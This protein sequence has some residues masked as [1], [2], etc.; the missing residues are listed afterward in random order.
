M[1]Q[2]APGC[3]LHDDWGVSSIRFEWPCTDLAAK[4]HACTYQYVRT[5]AGASASLSSPCLVV[6]WKRRRAARR[7]WTKGCCG[8]ARLRKI[9]PRG[10]CAS[11]W[12]PQALIAR[13]YRHAAPRRLLWYPYLTKPYPQPWRNP[14]RRRWYLP[15]GFWPVTAGSLDMRRAEAQS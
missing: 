9:M 13:L 3:S 11:R 4:F 10:R 5:K 8:K 6:A 15:V 14:C 12:A 2:I 1:A 7:W